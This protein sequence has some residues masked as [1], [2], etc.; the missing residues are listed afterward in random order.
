MTDTTMQMKERSEAI[1]RAQRGPTDVVLAP[2]PS[3]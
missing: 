2:T 3:R 1:G